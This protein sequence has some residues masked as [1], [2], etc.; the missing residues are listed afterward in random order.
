MKVLV[1]GAEGFA[2][3]R[4]VDALCE[5]GHEVTAAVRKG[6]EGPPGIRMMAIDMRDEESLER[7]VSSAAF[8]AV[9]H[10]AAVSSGSDALAQ[11]LVAWDV[12]ALGTVRLLS[13]LGRRRAQGHS[14]PVVL[15][16]STAEVYDVTIRRP[17]VETDQLRPR[18]PYAAS[19]LGAEIGAQEVGARTGLR[20][21]ISRTFPH[22]G[23]GQDDRFVLPVLGRRL[24]EARRTGATSVHVGNLEPVRDYL[25]VRDV[26]DAYVR[27]LERGRAGEVYNIASGVGHSLV[28][29]FARLSHLLGVSVTPVLDPALLRPMDVPYLVGDATKLREAT[30][31][32][33]RFD[34]DTTLADLVHAQAN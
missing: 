13:V 5:K 34:L 23:P 32:R 27:L 17:L 21:V 25:D 14:D 15:V 22:T 8:D 24:A 1:T 11:P 2:G 6:L 7:A 12:N 10:L 4:L 26:A 31:W 16:V 30:G 18:S 3:R 9:A 29:L 28:D 20:V 33:P 19:K